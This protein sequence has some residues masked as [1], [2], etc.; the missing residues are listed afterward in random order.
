MTET[1]VPPIET[2]PA[3]P[4]GGARI[5]SV[6][7][8]VVGSLLVNALY[9]AGKLRERPAIEL[10]FVFPGVEAEIRAW[11]E[12]DYEPF[13]DREDVCVV[14]MGHV[15]VHVASR[16][17]GIEE[18]LADEDD[19]AAR[20]ILDIVRA[21]LIRSIFGE[22]EEPFVDQSTGFHVLCWRSEQRKRLEPAA[23]HAWTRGAA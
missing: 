17:R 13:E 5:D 21:A 7:T 2:R 23:A 19:P 16:F 15:K 10:T 12:S 20:Q 22:V 14:W 6:L 1:K 9:T 4:A 3:I 18:D 11:T 8:A